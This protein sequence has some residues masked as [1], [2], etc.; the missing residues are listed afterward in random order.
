MGTADGQ[1]VV[2]NSESRTWELSGN[3]KEKSVKATTSYNVETFKSFNTSSGEISFAELKSIYLSDA[4][5]KEV[6]KIVDEIYSEDSKCDC[7]VCHWPS[8]CTWG[9][10]CSYQKRVPCSWCCP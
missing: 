7:T 1:K 4:P 2:F 9:S 3:Q 6:S 10:D 5:N 8:H